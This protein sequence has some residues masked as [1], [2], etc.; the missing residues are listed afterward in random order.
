MRSIEEK[1]QFLFRKLASIFR[2]HYWNRIKSFKR[3][4]RKQRTI[5]IVTLPAMN[6]Q[7]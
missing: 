4:E 1:Q 7:F 5:T 3:T 6:K 2:S